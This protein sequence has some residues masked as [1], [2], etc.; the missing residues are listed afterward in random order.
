MPTMAMSKSPVRFG[1]FASSDFKDGILHPCADR[2][3]R[4]T[5]KLQA[6]FQGPLAKLL[7]QDLFGFLWYN[8]D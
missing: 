7:A 1:S 2:L 8:L 5:F 6:L 3:G 4:A